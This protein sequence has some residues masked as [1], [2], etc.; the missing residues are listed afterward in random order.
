MMFQSLSEDPFGRDSIVPEGL[1]APANRTIDD[2]AAEQFL[3][4]V[5]LANAPVPAN[6]AL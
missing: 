4:S 6:P 1:V 3:F 2:E 5:E